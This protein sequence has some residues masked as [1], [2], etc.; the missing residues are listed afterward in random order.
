[1]LGAMTFA[2]N[3]GAPVRTVEY[4]SS[5]VIFCLQPVLHNHGVDLTVMQQVSNFMGA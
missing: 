3:A 5:G 2:G 1:M 4:L